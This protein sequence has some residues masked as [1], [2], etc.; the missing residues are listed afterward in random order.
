[1]NAAEKVREACRATADKHYKEG[2]A[3]GS[4]ALTAKLLV[5]SDNE[6]RALTAKTDADTKFANNAQ[7]WETAVSSHEK[8]KTAT[9]LERKLAGPALDAN[10]KVL[11]ET[12]V[13]LVRAAGVALADSKL[14]ADTANT[15][16]KK[17]CGQ[18]NAMTM[19]GINGDQKTVDELSVLVGKLDL[20]KASTSSAT[21][22]VTA[23]ATTV[24]ASMDVPPATALLE[25]TSCAEMEAQVMRFKQVLTPAPVLA[26]PTVTTAPLTATAATAIPV[27]GDLS[28]MKRRLEEYTAKATAEHT[29]C[30]NSAQTVKVAAEGKAGETRSNAANTAETDLTTKSQAL[31][32]KHNAE[33]AELDAALASNV[34]TYTAAET[35]QNN[36]DESKKSKGIAYESASAARATEEKEANTQWTDIDLPALIKTKEASFAKCSAALLTSNSAAGEAYTGGL[37]TIKSA[38]AANIKRLQDEMMTVQ[39][40]QNSLGNLKVVNT[41]VATAPVSTPP[42]TPATPAPA[43][44]VTPTPA[45]SE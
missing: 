30:L 27:S 2:E 41:E 45:A 6:A 5:L 32:K 19:E 21:S 16:A 31:T 38:K 9:E 12:K 29:Q 43:A 36:L 13:E 18:Q 26:P 22:G 24:A 28:D 37:D 25:L 20:C 10:L 23:P 7:A 39:S 35:K 15:A 3:K 11:K 40:V 34:K 14:A 33:I 8:V 1:M 17:I 4:A 44:T 42:A